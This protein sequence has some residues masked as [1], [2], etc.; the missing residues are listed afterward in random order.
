MAGFTI[1]K[2]S[3]VLN[4]PEAMRE[5]KTTVINNSPDA[6][7]TEGSSFA[8]T[9]NQAVD[10]VNDLQKN[11]DVKM[12]QLATGETNNIPEVMMAVEKADIAMKLMMSVRNKVVEAYQEV[13]KMQL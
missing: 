12:Q 7:K 1:D 10:K 6:N 4:T 5:F 13:M 9:L 2:G 3:S 8:D 11:A